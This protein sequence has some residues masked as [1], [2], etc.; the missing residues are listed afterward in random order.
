MT[1]RMALLGE[2]MAGVGRP[3]QPG[4][5]AAAERALR[6]AR[7]VGGRDQ[8]HGAIVHGRHDR[9]KP[10][11]LWAMST[12][13]LATAFAAFGC[14]AKSTIFSDRSASQLCPSPAARIW[15]FRLNRRRS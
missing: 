8:Q 12:I 11:P 2:R 13:L 1:K 5:V 10:P 7:D 3:A 14:V 4:A 9:A 6:R 15:R